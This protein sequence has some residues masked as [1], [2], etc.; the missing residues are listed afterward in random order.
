MDKQALEAARRVAAETA[1]QNYSFGENDQSVVDASPWVTLGDEF[2]RV[3][4]LEPDED[5]EGED[6][7]PQTI[8]VVAFVP[9]STEIESQYED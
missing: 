6:D 7:E 9:D 3:V 5:D 2:S 1:F 4:Y 8:F